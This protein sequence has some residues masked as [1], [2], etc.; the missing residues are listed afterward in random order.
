MYWLLGSLMVLGL[1]VWI[2]TRLFGNKSAA[3]FD[4]SASSRS[5][6][7]ASRSADCCGAHAVCERY[8]RK[9]I[10]IVEYYDDEHL[11]AYR[12]IADDTYP[13]DVVE[14]FREVLY[15]MLA[16]DVSGWMC[17]L[18]FRG[19]NLPTQLRDEALMLIDS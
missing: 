14:E 13:D 19:I 4:T 2:A 8:G 6:S 5:A 9:N 3:S 15:S 12:G 18:T 10:N 7:T 16:K 11:D 1:A 17:S